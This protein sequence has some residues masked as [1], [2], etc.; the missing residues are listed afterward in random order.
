MLRTASIPRLLIVVL[1][2]TMLAV[3]LACASEEEPTTAP[4]AAPTPT[5][6]AA[7]TPITVGQPTATPVD[8][9]DTEL[10]WMDRYLQSPGY[11]PEWGQPIRAGRTS[12]EPNGMV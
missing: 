7:A 8:R 6:P 11:N 5:T 12:L 4:T 1:A 2:T 3:A 10:G 9:T